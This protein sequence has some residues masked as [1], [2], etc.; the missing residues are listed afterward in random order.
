[1][2]ISYT[3]MDPEQG[4][5]RLHGIAADLYP[6]SARDMSKT[7][8]LSG[9]TVTTTSPTRTGRRIKLSRSRQDWSWRGVLKVL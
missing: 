9:Q 3:I 2:D 4:L 1:M 5:I 8:S 7:A 6:L